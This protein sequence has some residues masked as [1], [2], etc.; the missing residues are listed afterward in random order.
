MALDEPNDFDEVFTVDG[1]TY[2]VDK[3]L[4]PMVQPITVDFNGYTFSITGRGFGAYSQC[5]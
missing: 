3:H 1:F 4:L 2:L 5:G